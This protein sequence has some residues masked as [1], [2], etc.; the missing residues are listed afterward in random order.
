[1]TTKRTGRGDATRPTVDADPGTSEE[2]RREIADILAAGY[3]RLLRRRASEGPEIADTAP[4]SASEK[5][6]EKVAERP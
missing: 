2:L 3:L 6:A 5:L 4:N 1:M